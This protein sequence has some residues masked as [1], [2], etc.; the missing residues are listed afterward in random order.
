MNFRRIGLVGPILLILACEG[1]PQVKVETDEDK[2]LYAVGQ[3]MAV[4][5]ALKGLFSEQELKVVTQGFSDGVLG[6]NATFSIDEYMSRMNDLV[7]GRRATKNAEWGDD[8]RKDAA[9]EAG[10]VETES[11]LLYQELTAGTGAQPQATDEVTVHYTGQLVDGQVFDSSVKRGEPTTFPLTGVVP[12]WTE[13]L[14]MMRVGGKARLIIPSELA[15]GEDGS[16]G[17]IPP[18][19]T[20][21]FELELLGIK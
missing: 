6:H 16:R 20:L 17:V 7:Q 2:T 18:N 13:G 19:A 1:T 10:V 21:V 3:G 12:G 8:Y 11:G 5:F 9:A 14:Q 4:Q 15:Y